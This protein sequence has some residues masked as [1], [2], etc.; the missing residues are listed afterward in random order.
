MNTIRARSVGP[1]R[2]IGIGVAVALAAAGCAS[3]PSTPVVP[4][5]TSGEVSQDPGGVSA[6]GMRTFNESGLIFEYPASW[7]EFRGQSVSSFS[8]LI[9]YLG[10]VP[11][12]AS[13]SSKPVN[14]GVETQ[15]LEDYQL[16][17]NSLAVAIRA[18][19]FPNFSVLKVPA[20][21]ASIVIGGLPGYQEVGPTFPGDTSGAET[22]VTTTIAHPGLIDNYY[23]I[24][25][26]LRGPDVAPMRA[27]LDA[28]IASLRFDPPAVPLPAGD[29]AA[30]VAGTRA[31][32]ILRRD[33][34]QWGCFVAIGVSRMVVDAIPMGPGLSHPQLATCTSTMEAT[35]LELWKM[36]MTMRFSESVP[37][38]GSG[39]KY[40]VWVDA[41]GNPGLTS[42]GPIVGP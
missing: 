25:A 22:V 7:R 38:I 12:D 40:E 20:G 35:P 9:A 10:T 15:C 29:D 37:G 24:T 41:D 27:D 33:T 11:V 30:A 19:G 14:G 18:N 34:P 1:R 31:L 16:V 8:T 28:L 17:P 36:T 32:T 26:S 39:Q 23:T 3:T 21:A 6:S 5:T 42:G 4:D 13:C 2:A